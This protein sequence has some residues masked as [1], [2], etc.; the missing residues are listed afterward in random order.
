MNIQIILDKLILLPD[1][2]QIQV[3][4][5]IDY[6]VNKYVISNQ[7]NLQEQNISEN[8]DEIPLELKN[9]LNKRIEN[10]RKNSKNVVTWEEVEKQFEQK[11]G[12]EI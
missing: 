1:N 5:Y 11:Y 4:D 8:H 12:Y 2:I 6:L 3:G 10:Y 9:F 7:N